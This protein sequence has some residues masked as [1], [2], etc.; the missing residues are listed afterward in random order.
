MPSHSAAHPRQAHFPICCSHIRSSVVAVL[1]TGLEWLGGRPGM[2]AH[3]T[4]KPPQQQPDVAATEASTALIVERQLSGRGVGADRNSGGPGPEA[5]VFCRSFFSVCGRKV[6]HL[7]CVRRFHEGRGARDI[8]TTKVGISRQPVEPIDEAQHVPAMKYIRHGE[9]PG[10]T[11]SEQRDQRATLPGRGTFFFAVR[12]EAR[13]LITDSGLIR[14]G[15]LAW[16]HR[17]ETALAVERC[18]P[19]AVP[20]S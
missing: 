7:V 16:G 13:N 10:H 5:K 12:G 4:A 18:A 9:G 1:L 20:E 8:V 3:Q 17:T 15:C 19:G 6:R 14:P 2:R 11:G